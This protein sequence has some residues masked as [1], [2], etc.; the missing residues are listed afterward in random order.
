VAL[1]PGAG[2]V[3]GYGTMPYNTEGQHAYRRQPVRF[4]GTPMT[5]AP[6]SQASRPPDRGPVR[7]MPPPIS[8]Q[9]PTQR[10]QGLMTQAA[11]QGAQLARSQGFQKGQPEYDATMAHQQEI[12]KQ[13]LAQA[14]SRYGQMRMNQ[15]QQVQNQLPPE[16]VQQIQG[17]PTADPAAAWR[18]ISGAFTQQASQSGY[19]DPR[20]YLAWLLRN[21]QAGHPGMGV[22][23]QVPSGID[24][25]AVAADPNQK[26]Y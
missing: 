3:G 23:G 21:R 1:A 8:Y 22:V 14:A 25:A 19:Q 6:R 4:M 13:H 16:L 18:A 9:N 24:P 15:L 11:Q 10:Q 20:L 17:L 12:A 2:V 26:I 7:Q 5:Q